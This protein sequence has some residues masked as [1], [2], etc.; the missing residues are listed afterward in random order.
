MKDEIFELVDE[1]GNIIGEALRSDCH[2]NPDLLHRVAHVLVFRSNGDLILQ[3]R[4]AHKDIQPDKWDSSVGGHLDKGET[5]DIA[6]H[7]EMKEE[8]GIESDLQFIYSYIWRSDRESEL[9]STYTCI[10]DGELFPPADE[11]DELRDWSPAEIEESLGTGKFTENFE[12][13]WQKSKPYR[14]RK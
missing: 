13:E 10:Y 1:E 11:V 3:Y 14:M 4:P 8:L 7:R 12:L 9:V 5:P 2:S 6:A